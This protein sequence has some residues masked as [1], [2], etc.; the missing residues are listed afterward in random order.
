MTT[1][2]LA[3]RVMVMRLYDTSKT[4]LDV[5]VGPGYIYQR[6]DTE[7][8]LIEGYDTNDSVVAHGVINFETEITETSKFQQRF[9]ADYG[10]K[11]DARSETSLTAKYYRRIGDESLPLLSLQQR[12]AG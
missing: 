9:V 5:E 2:Y 6:L 7:Q 3:Q 1:P 12:A 10:D 8:A 4:F 11:L